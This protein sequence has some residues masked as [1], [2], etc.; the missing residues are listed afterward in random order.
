MQFYL[1]HSD[2]QEFWF[3]FVNEDL[4]QVAFS[5]DK[6]R[7][8]SEFRFKFKECKPTILIVS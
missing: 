7:S 2:E 6:G 8:S 3:W 4:Q 1:D 5:R